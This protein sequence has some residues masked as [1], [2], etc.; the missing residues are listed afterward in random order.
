MTGR[1]RLL[2]LGLWIGL[3]GLLQADLV[4][5][6]DGF[7]LQGRVKQES[8]TEFDPVSREPIV[9]PKGLMLLDDG[10][11]RCYIVPTQVRLA[12]KK[13][14]PIEEVA[15][16]ENR[17][18]VTVPRPVP[19]ILEVIEAPPFDDEWNRSIR[20]RTTWGQV[21]AKQELAIVGPYH[22]RADAFPRY[23]W[24][25]HFLTRELGVDQVR[26]L[27]STHKKFKVTP[28]L[29]AKEALSRRL[30]WCDFFLQAGWYD[31]AD[32]ELNRLLKTM[33]D[34]RESIEAGQAAVGRVRAREK[35]EELKR[36]SVAGL[37]ETAR[38]RGADF[39]EQH[40]TEETL[41][42]W[43]ELK[44][45]LE[46]VLARQER[47]GKH[48][49]LLARAVSGD[50]AKT[51][52]EA[53]LAI[54]TE[55]HPLGLGRLEAFL[56]QADQA[57]RQRDAGAMP[58]LSPP[59]LIG[60]A[61]TGWLLGNP[62]SEA[63][64]AVALR[65]WRLRHMVLEYLRSSIPNKRQ[66]A[67]DS[68]TRDLGSAPTVDEIA[69][70]VPHL[71]PVEPEPLAAGRRLDLTVESA[72]RR[73]GNYA[74]LLPP[75]YR[76]SRPTPVLLVLH[77]TNEKAEE[78]LDRW[79]EA[80]D[81][82]YLVAA[83]QWERQL[84]G[85]YHYTAA[86]HGIVLEV[87]RDLRRRFN[88]DSDRVFLS[89]LGHGGSMA[90]DVGLG[91]PDLF[92]GVLPVSGSPDFHSDRYWRNAQYLP[93][94]V[95]NGDRSGDSNKRTREQFTNWAGRGYP[96]LW[97]QYKGRGT[98]WFAGEVPNALDW[99]RSKRRFFPLQQLGTDGNRGNFG[100]EFQSL[101]HS[102]NS[103]YWLEATEIHDRCHATTDRWPNVSPAT[104][105]A[106]ID[107]ESNEII[108]RTAG[109]RKL[110]V[111]LGRGP[112]GE[113]LI[114]FDRNLSIRVNLNSRFAN[115]K[116]TPSLTTLLED[117]YQRGDRQRLFLAK[118]EIPL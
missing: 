75:E 66:E 93:F 112:N 54:K 72:A 57:Q 23:A 37:V 84:G 36:L 64:P 101:R 94:Y 20:F 24:S 25:A 48:L 58:S 29:P 98:E 45:E 39:P 73:D 77:D 18:G 116:V 90:F 26:R 109:V 108:I 105:T 11:R 92:A 6:K 99:M 114:D 115:R 12:E 82:G 22:S 107:K 43:R 100:N 78:M 7:V 32:A 56:G 60:L 27:L 21:Q 44:A 38:Q 8:K 76:H 118:I 19:A 88:V 50:D 17:L 74:L 28:D 63:K 91:H 31:E 117:L 1:C 97:I 13:E 65:L 46:S 62:A 104:L 34:F 113:N 103:F 68:C 80:A 69:R 85:G 110:T 3:V 96:S 42:G 4:F 86:E 61:V 33:P 67:L 79:A 53:A 81:H 15:A 95:I 52:A 30:R 47:L 87:L 35:Y 71:P 83:P 49:D 51:L 70:I 5:L 40:A 106:R 102:D 55:L 59:E 89:G 2:A 111:W 9:M 41:S 14:P 16:R 10:P